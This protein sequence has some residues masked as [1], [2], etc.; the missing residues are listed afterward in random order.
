MDTRFFQ[1]SFISQIC[2]F[3]TSEMKT[4]KASQCLEMHPRWLVLHTTDGRLRLGWRAGIQSPC[5]STYLAA[6]A[7]YS[8]HLAKVILCMGSYLN[9]I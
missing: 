9:A 3:P 5:I 8:A 6:A 4:E 2:T 7:S 1:E